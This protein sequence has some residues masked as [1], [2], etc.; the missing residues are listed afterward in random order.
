MLDEVWPLAAG[1]FRVHLAESLAAVGNWAE[2]RAM[3]TAADERLR[4]V[5]ATEFA[6]LA[7]VFIGVARGM[8]D[9]EESAEWTRIAEAAV[10]ALDARA[11][12][13]L[14]KRLAAA[15]VSGG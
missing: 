9:V 13:P 15:R 11:A 2:A 12:A 7:C 8:G 1:V 5:H 10:E 6:N 4:G 14:R 3:L